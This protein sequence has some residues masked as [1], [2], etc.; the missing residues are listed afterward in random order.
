ME[1]SRALGHDIEAENNCAHAIGTFKKDEMY[2][3]QIRQL[4]WILN[5]ENVT[6]FSLCPSV[7]VNSVFPLFLCPF[8]PLLIF[9]LSVSAPLS[10][11]L[12]SALF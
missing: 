3:A 8:V 5:K 9:F 6:S 11:V 7:D 2:Q 4:S 12:L 1:S 10:S